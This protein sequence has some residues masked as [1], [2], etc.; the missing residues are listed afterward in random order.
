MG[1]ISIVVNA[2]IPPNIMIQLNT[3]TFVNASAESDQRGHLLQYSGNTDSCQLLSYPTFTMQ[4]VALVLHV[5][6]MDS[7]LTLGKL[8]CCTVTSL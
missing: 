8:Q 5:A 1:A 3:I 7:E 6:A 2:A 4:P